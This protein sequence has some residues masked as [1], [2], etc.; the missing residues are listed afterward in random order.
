MT[1]S[2]TNYEAVW[3]KNNPDY[4]TVKLLTTATVGTAVNIQINDLTLKINPVYYEI[5]GFELV[6]HPERAAWVIDPYT[7][8]DLIYRV[9]TTDITATGLADETLTAI[10]NHI[11]NLNRGLNNGT[12]PKSITLEE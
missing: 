3:N 1:V 7:T 12:T 2:G 10:Q 5:L 9:I 8:D 6:E 11:T 4:I